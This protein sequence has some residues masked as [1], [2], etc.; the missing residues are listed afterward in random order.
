MSVDDVRG[1]DVDDYEVLVEMLT[2]Q[3]RMG[4]DDV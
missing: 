1:L 4:D 3:Q 2:D